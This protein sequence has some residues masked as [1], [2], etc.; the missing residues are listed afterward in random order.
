MT[1]TTLTTAQQDAAILDFF[2]ALCRVLDLVCP[3]R[4]PTSGSHGPPKPGGYR[5]T[6]SAIRDS[7]DHNQLPPMSAL[8]HLASWAL[9]ELQ[10]REQH[11]GLTPD[12]RRTQDAACRIYDVATELC[13][14]EGA[15]YV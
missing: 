8:A 14:Y 5:A 10:W 7:L 1:W 6:W 12:E 13:H 3:P 11:R 2:D 9:F 4:D 15:S